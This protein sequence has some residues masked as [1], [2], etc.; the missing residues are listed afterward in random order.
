M[1]RMTLMTIGI[2]TYEKFIVQL[3]C[4]PLINIYTSTV[5]YDHMSLRDLVKIFFTS[6]GMYI[7]YDM[8]T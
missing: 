8:C 3:H 4:F 6:N 1:C 2:G 7:M 5:D